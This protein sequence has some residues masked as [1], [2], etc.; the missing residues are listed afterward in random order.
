MTSSPRTALRRRLWSSALIA[1]VALT[2]ACGGDA[3]SAE[4]DAGPAEEAAAEPTEESLRAFADAYVETLNDKDQQTADEMAC[5]G[6]SAIYSTYITNDTTWEV[7]EVHFGVERSSV[8]FNFRDLPT[9]E[10]FAAGFTAVF[11]DGEWCAEQ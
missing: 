2:T 8:V 10:D 1:S 9:S 7:T 6:T 5:E 4:P 11:V 3:D